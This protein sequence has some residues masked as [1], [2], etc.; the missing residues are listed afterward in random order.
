MT[1]AAC[2]FALVGVAVLPVALDTPAGALSAPAEASSLTLSLSVEQPRIVAPF[3]ARV[4]LHLHNAGASPLWL[5]RHV[6][7]PHE[8]EEARFRAAESAP[9]PAGSTGGGS[10]VVI[11]FEPAEAEKS[12]TPQASEQ[13]SGRNDGRDSGSDELPRSRVLASVGMP[14]ARLVRLA[15]GADATEGV[16]IELQPAIVAGG[17]REEPVWGRYQLS[18]TYNAVYSNGAALSR[19]LA[20]E[21]WQ[22]TVNSNAVEV[23]LEPA[24]PPPSAAGSVAGRIA[25]QDGQPLPYMLVSLSDHEDHLVGQETTDEQGKYSFNHLPWGIYWVTARR[26]GSTY[27]TATYEHVDL[28]AGDPIATL[29]LVMLEPEVYEPK[30]MLHKPVLLKVTS[31]SGQPL[32]GVGIE[33]LWSSG[34]VAETLKA[35]TAEDGT[36]TLELIP[37][38]NY[39]TLKR[40][41]CRNEDRRV[42]VAAGDG[43][44]GMSLQFDCNG[45]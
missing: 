21:V 20:V 39:V 45:S 42:D 13:S 12:A 44:D 16:V 6:R 40:H 7:D 18:V 22:G 31:S 10:S 4:T 34:S 30:Q 41:G 29:N 5:Y 36:A 25:Q 2:A 19:N 28:E 33:A 15:P 17:D 3:P 37:G 27:E 38:R 35:E 8:L 32:Q 1:A 26:P 9:S 24:P 23:D 11:H 43:I 14:H